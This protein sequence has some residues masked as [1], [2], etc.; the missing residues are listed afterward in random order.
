MRSEGDEL[1]HADRRTDRHHKAKSRFSQF[2]E[3]A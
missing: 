2:C 3:R 1:F